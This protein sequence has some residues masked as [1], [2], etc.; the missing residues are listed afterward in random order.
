MTR[1]PYIIVLGNEKGG[2]G[3]STLSM[4]IIVS[5]LRQGYTMGSI[6]VD[7][8]QGTLSRY[9]QNRK[10]KQE[11]SEEDLPLPIHHALHKSTNNNLEKAHAEDRENFANTIEEL[12]EKNC[13]YILVDTPGN[14]TYLSRVAHS[15]AS[16]LITPIN[17]SYIDLDMLVRLDNDQETIIKPSLYAETVWEQKMERAKRDGGI[18]DWIVVRNRMSSIHSNNKSGI[19]KVLGALASRI[20]FRLVSGFSERVIFKEL[21]LQ[22]ITLV[23]LTEM[24]IQMKLSHVAARNELT[25]LMQA[26]F[27]S[28]SR[29]LKFV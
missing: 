25:Q 15:Y 12:K 1:T 3:K 22:G 11:I 8:R 4:H 16:T 13:D 27:A 18:I 6:D 24:G 10:K 21:F 19:E 2:T 5:L 9:V 28:K 17:D 26:I 23:D 7:A 29:A 20:G 14:D